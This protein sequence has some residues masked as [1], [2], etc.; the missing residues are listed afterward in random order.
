MKYHKRLCPVCDTHLRKSERDNKPCN[1]C[2]VEINEHWRAMN[3]W[4]KYL[5]ASGA[6]FRD[7]VRSAVDMERTVQ[8]AIIDE[9]RE[10]RTSLAKEEE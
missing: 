10:I 3:K 8:S 5:L 4:G 2:L 6:P 9:V 1:A 7:I